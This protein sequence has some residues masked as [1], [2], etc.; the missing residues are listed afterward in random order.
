MRYQLERTTWIPR[1]PHEVFSFFASARNL[2]RI[3]PAFLRFHI[4]TPDP[5][6][7]R[8][9]TR[10]DYELTLHGVRLRWRTLIE[11]FVEDSHFVDLQL[12]GPYRYWRHRHDFK[13]IDGGTLM[14]DR[15]DYELP[16]GPLGRI[17]RRLFVR[18]SLDRI[19][20]HRAK[21]IQE[22]FGTKR[23]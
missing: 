8:A 13:A 14:L 17:V 22:H 9:G 11:E 1:P 6:V 18:S 20:D 7:M 19:F 3:T 12:S 23:S 4:L 2:E 15:V 10:I 16:M 21:V 5:I